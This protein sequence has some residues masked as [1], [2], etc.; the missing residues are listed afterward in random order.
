MLFSR[1]VAPMEYL[2]EE[3]FKLKATIIKYE[4]FLLRVSL[5]FPAQIFFAV[6]LVCF[7]VLQDLGFCVHIR[8]PHKV[9]QPYNCI[10]SGK[11][12]HA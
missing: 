5:V 11:G 10:G 3:Y 8:H 9:G 1:P 7:P 4:R 12:Y 6:Y 2:G